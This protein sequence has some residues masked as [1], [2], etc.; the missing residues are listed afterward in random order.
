MSRRMPEVARKRRWT[1]AAG[2]LV[3]VGAG[4]G[5]A[6]AM[7]GGAAGQAACQGQNLTFS[8]EGGAPGVTSNQFKV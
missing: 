5:S 6:F 3:V 7:G 8:A 1:I 2:L 4:A